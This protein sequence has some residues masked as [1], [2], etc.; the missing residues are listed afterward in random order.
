M[1]LSHWQKV[2]SWST[3]T[4]NHEAETPTLES[5]AHQVG[6]QELLEHQCGTGEQ[7]GAAW[8][9]CS[10][11]GWKC[12]PKSKRVMPSASHAKCMWKGDLETYVI[13][14]DENPRKTDSFVFGIPEIPCLRSMAME[15]VSLRSALHSCCQ[16]HGALEHVWDPLCN[17]GFILSLVRTWRMEARKKQET[18][19][20]LVPLFQN[21]TFMLSCSFWDSA[22]IRETE[23]SFQP[24]RKQKLHIY[25]TCLVITLLYPST[26]NMGHK[27]GWVVEVAD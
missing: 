21:E 11:R 7:L 17:Y 22:V 2:D 26:Q 20:T 5:C 25:C 13:L 9:H 14:S 15:K 19:L 18:K 1:H 16:L 10:Q 12:Y 24:W 27:N 4:R 8:Q 3:S 23:S 6:K